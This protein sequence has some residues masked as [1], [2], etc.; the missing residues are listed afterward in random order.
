MLLNVYLEG[1]IEVDNLSAFDPRIA[2]YKIAFH[3]ASHCDSR[4]RTHHCGL[5]GKR[6]LVAI[7]NGHVSGP[8]Q[9]ALL[10]DGRSANHRRGLTAHYA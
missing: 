6:L 3:N 9:G 7:S 1:G 8:S 4:S 5:S 10:G 2:L